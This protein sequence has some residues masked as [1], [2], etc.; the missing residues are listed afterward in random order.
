MQTRHII[1]AGSIYMRIIACIEKRLVLTYNFSKVSLFNK[2][3]F[4]WRNCS[5]WEKNAQLTTWCDFNTIYLRTSSLATEET[6]FFVRKLA[7]CP[8]F[9]SHS[10]IL[11]Q[12]EMKYTVGLSDSILSLCH[13]PSPFLL[14]VNWGRKYKKA[15]H[16]AAE[17]LQHDIIQ[18]HYYI[19]EIAP[20]H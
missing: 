20:A 11:A 12:S 1:N 6:I 18:Y 2:P 15:L 8:T 3:H 9:A 10:H 4:D 17:K 7:A 16:F 14:N 19:F 13:A 5:C